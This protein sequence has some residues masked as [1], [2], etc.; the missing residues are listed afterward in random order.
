M[1]TP[2]RETERPADAAAA[3]N[4]DIKPEQWMIANPGAVVLDAAGQEIGTVRETLPEYLQLKVK[5]NLLTDIE[6]YLPRELVSH[7]THDRVHV[8][9]TLDEL[10]QMNLTTP[11]ALR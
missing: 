11:P 1:T 4:P 6:L 3:E 9:H 7:A 8:A 10:K 2:H 5:E